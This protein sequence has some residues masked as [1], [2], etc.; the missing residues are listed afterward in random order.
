MLNFIT[1]FDKR[2]LSRGLVLYHSLKN[3]C[4]EE[5][6][7]YILSMDDYVYDYFTK[8]EYKFVYVI[9][10][11]EIIEYYPVLNK[12]KKERSS[13]EFCWTLSSFSI[14]FALQNYN[15]EECIYLDADL[16]FY[17]SPR[18]L[19]DELSRESVMITEHNYSS[20]VDDSRVSGKFCVQFMYF[21]N[22]ANGNKVLEWWRNKCEEWCFNRIEEGRFGDQKYLDDWE[23]RF[24]GL[25]YNCRTVGCGLAPW[26]CQKYYLIKDND[27]IYVQDRI[28]K[29]KK[30]LVFYHFHNLHKL[31]NSMWTLSNYRLSEDVIPLYKQYISRLIKIEENLPDQ[32]SSDEEDLDDLKEKHKVI[33]C[34]YGGL[35]H[36][37]YLYRKI[38]QVEKNVI[39]F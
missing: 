36:I 6:R 27:T 23:S 14:Q 39:K 35:K 17:S 24:E 8:K 31:H 25:V 2:Y 16:C 3:N 22:D 29:V 21:K 4:D 7:L 33:R 10:L 12:L 13:G 11:N 38:S 9:S 37:F 20:D 28:S 30:P 1:L 15:L 5:F 34:V 32:Y 19:V 18:L 26:N